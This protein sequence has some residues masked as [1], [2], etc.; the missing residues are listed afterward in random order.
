M[1]LLNDL[2]IVKF[3]FC[4]EMARKGMLLVIHDLIR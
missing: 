2:V 1:T 4:Q 3:L